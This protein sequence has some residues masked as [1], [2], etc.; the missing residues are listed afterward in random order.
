[1][2]Q[3][4]I[5][6]FKKTFKNI[7]FP[8]FED[9]PKASCQKLLDKIIKRIGVTS[10]SEVIELIR[11]PSN[12]SKTSYAAE[13]NFNLLKYLNKQNIRPNKFIYINWGHFD[14]IDKMAINDFSTYFDDIWYQGPDDIDIFDS[15]LNW[16]LSIDHSG[17]TKI[18]RFPR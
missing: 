8:W 13:D 3:F 2:E 4:K 18:M 16:I 7:N 9:L 14:Q 6:V 11:V 1:M 12:W 17:F 5:E 10:L 15:T